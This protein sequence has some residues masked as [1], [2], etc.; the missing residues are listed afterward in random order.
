MAVACS[1]SFNWTPSLGTKCH[2]KKK[3]KLI[4]LM[5]LPETDP[6]GDLSK[7]C[8]QVVLDAPKGSTQAWVIIPGRARQP[9]GT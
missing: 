2:I 4:S 9:S 8:V 5:Y 7:P 3:K 1:C 6:R